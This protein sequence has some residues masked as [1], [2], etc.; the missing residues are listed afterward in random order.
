RA[1]RCL[2]DDRGLLFVV[3]VGSALADASWYEQDAAAEW[4]RALESAGFKLLK[5]EDEV[6][7]RHKRHKLL[8]WVLETAPIKDDV[9]LKPMTTPKDLGLK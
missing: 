9:E 3:E 1:R 6:V 8:Q 5:F 4:S 2:K 7:D